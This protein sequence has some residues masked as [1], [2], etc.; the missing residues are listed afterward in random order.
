MPDGGR[1]ITSA[2]LVKFSVSMTPD[3]VDRLDLIAKSDRISRS[4]VL[5]Q[6]AE[7]GLPLR[8]RQLTANE[9]AA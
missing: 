8:E 2:G 5:R 1:S 7:I 6:V 3:E 9:D 4:A